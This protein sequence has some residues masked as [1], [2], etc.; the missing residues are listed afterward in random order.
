MYEFAAIMALVRTRK[1]HLVP[2]FWQCVRNRSIKDFF[3]I[4]VCYIVDA[5]ISQWREP[6]LCGE[7][8]T[9]WPQKTADILNYPQRQRATQKRNNA[10][11]KEKRIQDPALVIGRSPSVAPVRSLRRKRFRAIS[12]QRTRNESQRPRIKLREWKSGEGV[13]NRKK[14]SGPLCPVVGGGGGGLGTHPSHPPPYGP[15]P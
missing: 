4:N 10:Y 14:K 5:L 3:Q 8:T 15:D 6:L 13:V 12:E 11:V 1:R 7:Y 9:F 2:N